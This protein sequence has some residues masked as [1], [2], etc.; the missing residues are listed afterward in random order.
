M[1][2]L[3]EPFWLLLVTLSE[4]ELGQTIEF[5]R[6]ENRILRDKLPERIT[7]TPRERNRLVKLGAKLG[8]AFNGIITIVTPRTFARWKIAETSEKKASGE[9][10]RKAGRPKTAE[11][12]RDVVLR[13]A[14]ENG[15]EYTR[16]L[17]ELKK[18][19][20]KNV[21]KVRRLSEHPYEAPK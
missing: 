2:R 19:G 3:L 11:S 1:P 15:W 14:R 20:I 5:L 4:K 6:E 16:I 12:V 18:L 17:G 13:L 8:S 9:S 21:L 10:D 7:I